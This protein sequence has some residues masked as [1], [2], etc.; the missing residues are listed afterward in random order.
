MVDKTLLEGA[1]A[2]SLLQNGNSGGG[3]GEGINGRLPTPALDA[4]LNGTTLS[5]PS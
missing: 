2:L 1:V 3:G 4:L 5:L